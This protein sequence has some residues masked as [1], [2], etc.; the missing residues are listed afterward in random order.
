MNRVTS[1]TRSSITTHASSFV[2]CFATSASVY[3]G[4]TFG[5]AFASKLWPPKVAV[6]AGASSEAA[7]AAVGAAAGAGFGRGGVV[8][9][10][11][12]ALPC[13]RGGRKLRPRGF[14]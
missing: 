10:R 11:A 5:S 14:A 4:S 9:R 7:A 13:V 6:G 1:Y 2:Q 12:A 8:P 3:F